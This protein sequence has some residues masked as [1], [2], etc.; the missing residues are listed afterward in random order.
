[1]LLFPKVDLIVGRVLP[2]LRHRW[3][4][5]CSFDAKRNEQGRFVGLKNQGCTCYMNSLLQQVTYRIFRPTAGFL[6]LGFV[7]HYRD[8][9]YFLPI[10]VELCG[11]SFFS[12]SLNPFSRRRFR[13]PCGNLGN[14]YHSSF[15]Q[16][17]CSN[18]FCLVSPPP[19]RVRCWCLMIHLERY[20]CGMICA[21]RVRLD[22]IATTAVHGA[23]A[24][25]SDS[26]G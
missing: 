25:K 8:G 22:G 18:A 14:R 1:M 7:Q 5:E 19:P 16:Y 17:Y 6:V 13:H 12:R 26:R 9:Y 24:T 10:F 23:C 11:I 3:G 20:L 2:S 15:L 21:S 4:Y